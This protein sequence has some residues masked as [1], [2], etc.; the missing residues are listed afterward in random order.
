MQENVAGGNKSQPFCQLFVNKVNATKLDT[1]THSIDMCEYNFN[2]YFR[3]KNWKVG[4]RDW[5]RAMYNFLSFLLIQYK[6]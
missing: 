4:V 2:L 1:H 3:K 5:D 6:Y